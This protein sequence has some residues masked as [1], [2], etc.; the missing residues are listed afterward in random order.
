MIIIIFCICEYFYYI[1]V[2]SILLLGRKKF[3]E[4]YEIREFM[5]VMIAMINSKRLL[6]PKIFDL[7]HVYYTFLLPDK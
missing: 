4:N 3:E 6:A 2:M 1:F 7:T 5:Q